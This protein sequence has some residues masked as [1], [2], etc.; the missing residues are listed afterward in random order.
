MS[1]TLCDICRVLV[2]NNE[3]NPAEI[4]INFPDVTK[5]EP[6]NPVLAS[7]VLRETK[8]SSL[9][10]ETFSANRQVKNQ[11]ST[12]ILRIHC[13]RVGKMYNYIKLLL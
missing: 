3:E 6:N 4:I 7:A 8:T 1:L 13:K 2:I 5:T 10:Q 12:L 9:W 11:S